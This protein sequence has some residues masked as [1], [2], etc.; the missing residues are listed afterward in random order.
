MIFAGAQTME[1]E[2]ECVGGYVLL[3]EG[4]ACLLPPFYLLL[5]FSFWVRVCWMF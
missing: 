1:G 2:M 3:I 4:L 5:P